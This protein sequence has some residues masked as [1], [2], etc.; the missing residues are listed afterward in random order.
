LKPKGRT[1]GS[2]SKPQLVFAMVMDLNP[3]IAA[4]APNM[5]DTFGATAAARPAAMKSLLFIDSTPLQFQL[6]CTV[7]PISAVFLKIAKKFTK[8]HPFST[9]PHLGAGVQSHFSME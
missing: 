1:I 6:T 8:H 3:D 5:V 4:T 7:S 9:R 2:R